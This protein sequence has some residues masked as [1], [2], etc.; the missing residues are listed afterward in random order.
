MAT[1]APEKMEFQTE[2]KQLLNLMIHSLYSNKEI[3]LRE[4]ISNASD[5]VDKARFEAITDSA[6]LG[7][8]PNFK[9]RIQ[10][11]GE[12]TT[13]ACT[14]T[15]A[16]FTATD[17]LIAGGGFMQ[18]QPIEVRRQAFVDG[19]RAIDT[20]KTVI[21][22]TQIETVRTHRYRLGIKGI[23]SQAVPGPNRTDGVKRAPGIHPGQ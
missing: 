9:I 23:E 15:L 4:L 17:T 2:V 7:D 10:A 8:E 19:Q 5:A 16:V 14:Q 12:L 20:I 22:G 18:A 1:T 6:L 13:Q 11:K 3:F 21:G